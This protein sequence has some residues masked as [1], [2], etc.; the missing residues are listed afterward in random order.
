MTCRAKT[1]LPFWAG[2]AVAIAAAFLIPPLA[3][4]GE[5]QPAQ[6]AGELIAKAKADLAGGDGIAAEGHLRQAIDKGA[7][8]PDVAAFMG[9]AMLQQGDP[10]KARRWLEQGNFAEGTAA[11]GFRALARLEQLEGNLPAAGKAF[12]RAI[13][14]TP[15]DATMWVEIGR[16]RYV[17]AE[18]LLAIK[19]ADYALKLDPENV[20]ALEF[21]GQIVRDQVGLVAALPWFKAALERAPDDLSVLGEYAATLGELGR[22]RE[23]LAVTRK[24]IELDPKNPRAF[25]LQAV[26][27]ARAGK[28]RLARSLLSRV[29]TALSDVPGAMLLEGVLQIRA[30]NYYLAIEAL[31][32]LSKLQPANPKARAL[33]ARANYLAGEYR[34]VVRRFGAEALQQGVSPYLQTL[35]ARSYEA[36]GQ[37]D[38]AAPL[39]DRAAFRP[40]GP[41]APVRRG[42]RIGTLIAQGK[43]DEAETLAEADR[44]DN[45][46]SAINQSLAGDVQLAKGDGAAALVRYR[47]AARVRLSE[48]L[49]VRMVTALLMENDRSEARRFAESFLYW[50]PTSKLAQR[51]CGSLAADDGDWSRAR[52]LFERLEANGSDRDVALMSELALVQLRDGDAVAAEA[53]ARKAYRLQRSSPIAAQAWAL[54]LAT[55]GQ[56]PQNAESLL[57]KARSIMGDSRLLTEGRRLLSANSKG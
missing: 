14:L 5:A 17:G 57:R 56:D 32:K 53:T 40:D 6:S 12:D 7:S 3:S 26:L 39:L 46:G 43:Y 31:E 19:A 45:P 21:R 44:A 54:S 38:M 41:I 1:H 22:A 27:A 11:I 52:M 30:E 35:V 15:K 8:R 42:S 24:M 49:F 16:L 20:R 34:S 18:H 37:R 13:A 36:I 25:Y 4:P 10:D 33:L 2:L 50:N 23:M 55:L 28:N 47:Q 9:E 48:S 29:D 51:I